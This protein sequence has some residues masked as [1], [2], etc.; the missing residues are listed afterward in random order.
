MYV[1]IVSIRTISSYLSLK[2]DISFSCCCSAAAVYKFVIQRRFWLTEFVT[3]EA[4]PSK[5]LWIL[6]SNNHFTRHTVCLQWR[7]LQMFRKCVANACLRKMLL[8]RTLRPKK[9]HNTI[10]FESTKTR[11]LIGVNG[12]W[13]SGRVSLTLLVDNDFITVPYIVA[14]QLF[15]HVFHFFRTVSI[16]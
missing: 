16:A 10:S 4:K 3:I 8:E 7:L 13:C 9:A 15:V 14:V 1:G 5:T 12:V 2:M 6:Y 11:R